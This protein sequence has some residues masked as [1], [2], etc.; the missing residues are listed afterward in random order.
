MKKAI[1]LLLCSCLLLFNCTKEAKIKLPP[2][3]NKLVVTS[4][5]SPNDYNIVV[6]VRNANPKF[7]WSGFWG[8]QDNNIT[9]ASIFISDGITQIRVPF[10]SV[11][12]L[13]LVPASDLPI[14]SGKT[15]Y[16]SVSTPDGR[17]VTAETTVPSGTLSLNKFE[18]N[19][20]GND[21]DHVNIKALISIPDLPE[22]T[23][24]TGSFDVI[25]S[26]DSLPY[27]T[28]NNQSYFFSA[29]DEFQTYQ[30]YVK[31]EQI[32]VYSAA[33]Y[34]FIELGVTLL[35]SDKHFYLY[36]KTVRLAQGSGDNPF[37]DP[38]MVYSNI[39]GGLGCFGSYVRSLYNKQIR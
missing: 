37:S 10:D 18:V 35:N 36:H 3:E 4:F 8:P 1:L 23:Y 14:Q 29:S 32:D 25:T 11:K 38:V 2:Q 34:P 7:N 20:S 17:K 27:Y 39:N 31:S 15:Y 24:I 26:A 6:T 12:G 9:D 30:E 21:T 13:Y 33:Y 28:N 5:I 22:T 19:Q 16:L